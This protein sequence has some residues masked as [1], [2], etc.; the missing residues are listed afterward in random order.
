MTSFRAGELPRKSVR[1]KG[2]LGHPYG[3]HGHE[4]PWP[5]RT[6]RQ[7]SRILA[8]LSRKR[9]LPSLDVR[10]KESGKPPWESQDS[11]RRLRVGDLRRRQPRQF[12][13]NGSAR[14]LRPRH[15]ARSGSLDS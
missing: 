7:T 2:T 14:L 6:T 15:D 12:R 1:D 11:G 13:E 4:F 3:R 5:L 9:M 10:G 8:S